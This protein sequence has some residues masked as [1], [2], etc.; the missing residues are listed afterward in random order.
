M[1]PTEKKAKADCAA[2]AKVLGLSEPVVEKRRGYFYGRAGVL[3]THPGSAF[4]GGAWR[5]L[6]DAL[7][8]R[9]QRLL[10]AGVGWRYLDGLA[11]TARREKAVEYAAAGVTRVQRQ[12][13]DAKAT[14]DRYAAEAAAARVSLAGLETTTDVHARD[15]AE[16]LF[17]AG[18]V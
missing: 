17:A 9:A 6:R 3:V 18:V 4:D 1:S 12:L 2:L 8:D 5:A 11:E 13:D 7:M 10:Y 16:A 14:L 15:V